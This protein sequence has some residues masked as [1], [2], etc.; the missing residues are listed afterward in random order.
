MKCERTIKRKVLTVRITKQSIINSYIKVSKLVK[1]KGMGKC[2][3]NKCK[4]KEIMGHH[5]SIR[6]GKS[7]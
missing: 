4:Y 5:F 6:Q 7:K 2:I 3:L 1:N